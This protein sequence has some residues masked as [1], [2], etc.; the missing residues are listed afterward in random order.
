MRLTQRSHSA[1][2]MLVVAGLVQS[3]APFAWGRV[4]A[5]P[6]ATRQAAAAQKPPAA[7]APATAKP[8]A[9]ATPA[10]APIDGGWP[11][12]YTLPPGGQ[13]IVYQPQVSTWDGQRHM[14][15]FSAVS[16][17]ETSTAKPALGTI[18][19]EA[20][21]SVATTE[22]LVSFKALKIS[23]AT[24][25][26]LEKIACARSSPRSTRAFRTTIAS[27]RWIACCPTSTRAASCRK[28]STA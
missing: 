6:A 26:T 19:I 11:R 4:A 14:V 27:S 24:F 9:T 15:A 28:T 13:V 5:A 12:R 1:V 23:Q 17:T 16:Y 3:S 8:A 25:P 2:S 7:K 21:T 22:R 20:D 10:A 18:K